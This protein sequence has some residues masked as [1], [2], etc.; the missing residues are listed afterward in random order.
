MH[1]ITPLWNRPDVIGPKVAAALGQMP[2]E[3]DDGALV[4]QDED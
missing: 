3:L 4:T 2:H 1:R